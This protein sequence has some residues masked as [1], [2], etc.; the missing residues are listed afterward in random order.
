MTVKQINTHTVPEQ[1]LNISK[2]MTTK[3]TSTIFLSK[4]H[5]TTLTFCQ[6]IILLYTSSR[7]TESSTLISIPILV[8]TQQASILVIEN[9]TDKFSLQYGQSV[10][11]VSVG[12]IAFIKW[13]KKTET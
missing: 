13:V 1:K 12:C 9:I 2:K 5:K 7:L 10:S 11:S 3:G 8:S 6:V 4:D